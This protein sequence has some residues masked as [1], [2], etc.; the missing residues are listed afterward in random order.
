MDQRDPSQPE[1]TF[2]MIVA[3]VQA[4]WNCRIF[5]AGFDRSCMDAAGLLI[6][7]TTLSD[8]PIYQAAWLAEYYR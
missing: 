5:K 8:D 2:T 4:E 3:I 7:V 6:W 1:E